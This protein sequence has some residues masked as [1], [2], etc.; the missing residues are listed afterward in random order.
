[1]TTRLQTLKSDQG[2]LAIHTHSCYVLAIY[3]G[4]KN[5]PWG[6]SLRNNL[7]VQKPAALRVEAGGGDED[8]H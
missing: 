3:V 1:M 2:L 7:C 6:L 8:L 4:S 5:V